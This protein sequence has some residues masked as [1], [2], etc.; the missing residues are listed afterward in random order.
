M[1]TRKTGF[2]LIGIGILGAIASLMVDLLPGGKPGIQSAQILGIEI[3]ILLLLLGVWIDLAARNEKINGI[4]NIHDGISRVLNLPI[5]VW[6][7]LG[8]LLA[9]ILF[10]I[11]PMFLNPVLRIDY[12]TR[13]LPDKSP[14]G[15]DLIAVLDL[16]KGWFIDGESP[17]AVQFYPPF[18]YIFFAPLLLVED[19]PALYK[20]FTLFSLLSYCLL[21]LI[22]PIKL[23]HNKHTPLILLLFITGLCS[24]GFQFE[25]E[26]G[27][28]NVFTFLLC[29]WAVYIFHYQPRYRIFAYLLFSMAIQLK[30]YP[31]IFIVMFV[32]DW[33]NWRKIL[34]RFTGIGVFNVLLLFMMGY[35][36]FLD[37]LH[38]VTTQLATPAW[39]WNGNHSLDAFVFNLTKDGFRILPSPT[40]EWLRQHSELVRTLLFLGFIILFA[41]ALWISYRRNKAGLDAYLF[42]SCTIGALILPIS[43][44]YTLSILAAPIALLLSNVP[45]TRKFP[46][47]V[48]SIFLVLGISFAYSSMLVP[49]KYKPYYLN[50][51]FPPLFL[52]LILAT[53]LNLIRYQSAET[54]VVE[55]TG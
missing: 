41:F 44:D 17:Y 21:T 50:N 32:D 5:I 54:P 40:L 24:Y 12:F 47:K 19:Y 31:A 29:L 10:V 23:T 51:A 1:I 39:T 25:L 16:M 13:Y 11:G 33:K 9:F 26:R 37:F 55:R 18:T 38:A 46:Q 49:F 7:L 3:S 28:Y 45:E 15:N 20:F 52:I 30:I 53:I 2:G 27:Q 14:I 42:L 35:K 36:I 8:F 22:L 34:L 48:I 4:Q 6:V 43:N